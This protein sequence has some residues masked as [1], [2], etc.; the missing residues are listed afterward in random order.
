[1]KDILVFL[2]ACTF[3][4][5]GTL[6]LLTNHMKAEFQRYGMEKFRTLTGVLEVLG[7]LG[8]LSGLYYT[9]LMVISSGGLA[10]LMLMGTVVRIR[11]KDA[12]LEII[13][14]FSLMLLNTYILL[15][16][17]GT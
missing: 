14:A 15:K 9:P 10:T 1:M 4:F 12:F 17:L 8:L 3:I 11:C 5:Y 2:S 7:G 16:T 13:P 6:C